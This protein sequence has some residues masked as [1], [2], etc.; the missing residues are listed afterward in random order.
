MGSCVG[1]TEKT[2][3]F[4]IV[5][6]LRLEQFAPFP[7]LTT[8]STIPAPVLRSEM[9]RDP[10]HYC[11]YDVMLVKSSLLNELSDDQRRALAVWVKAG[12]RLFI[13]AVRS[14]SPRS[15][16]VPARGNIARSASRLRRRL[17]LGGVFWD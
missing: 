4:R 12:G 7:N 8:V 1:E 17:C 2:E 6:G 5:R 14:F 15:R 9:P 3:T 10:F 13:I 16:G 11:V